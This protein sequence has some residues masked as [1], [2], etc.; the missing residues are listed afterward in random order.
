MAKPAASSPALLI[1]NPLESFSIDF[2]PSR[3][4]IPSWRWV[5]MAAMLLLI[6]ILPPCFGY[7]IDDIIVV[8]FSTLLP[9]LSV[10]AATFSRPT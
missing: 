6:R 9:C 1:L 8:T 5:L 7:K 2:E 4:L 3:E 10:E